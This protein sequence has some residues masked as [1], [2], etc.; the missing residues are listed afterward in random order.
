MPPI[1]TEL[2]SSPDEP[3]IIE[4]SNG[5]QSIRLTTS[6]KDRVTLGRSED[7]FVL[8]RTDL[9]EDNIDLGAAPLHAILSVLVSEDPFPGQRLDL[10]NERGG[11]GVGEM[12][13]AK[14]YSENKG[15]V[16]QLEKAGWLAR[17]VSSSLGQMHNVLALISVCSLTY[18]GSLRSGREIKQGFVTLPMMSIELSERALSHSCASCE[19]WE[20]PTDS[21]RMPKCGKCKRRWYCNQEHQLEHWDE[22]KKVCKLLQQGR[23]A[24]VENN[25][26]KAVH[27]FMQNY[28]QQEHDHLT[29]SERDAQN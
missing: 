4:H 1:S 5:L 29:H 14:T 27:Q 9:T 28:S 3:E 12:I 21:T 17:S 25:K 26:R 23:L 16:E 2:D 10:L 22:H 13:W 18:H 19:R 7:L 6:N 20:Q 8:V 15:I 11:N 24:T